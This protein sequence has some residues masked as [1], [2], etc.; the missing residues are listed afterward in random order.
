MQVFNGIY[1]LTDLEKDKR[2]KTL[3]EHRKIPPM[4]IYHVPASALNM[5]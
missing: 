4:H 3:A 2:G 5:T 1:N